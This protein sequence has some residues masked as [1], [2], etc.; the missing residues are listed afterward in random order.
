MAHGGAELLEHSRGRQV[1]KLTQGVDTKITE[2]ALVDRGQGQPTHWQRAQERLLGCTQHH[3][4]GPG[5]GTTSGG[6]GGK[7]TLIAAD[8]RLQR[9]TEGAANAG[10][11]GSAEAGSAAFVQVGLRR[12]R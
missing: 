11:Q 8:G 9:L 1:G 4:H 2:Q 3:A 5:A 7:F 6:R 12:G 10:P